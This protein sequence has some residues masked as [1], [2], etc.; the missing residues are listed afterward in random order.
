MN[1]LFIKRQSKTYE[2]VFI[3]AIEE[4]VGKQAKVK[5]FLCY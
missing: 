4:K 1:S 3:V 2:I 5:S